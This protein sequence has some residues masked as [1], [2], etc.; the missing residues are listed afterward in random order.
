ME[1][2]TKSSI[3]AQVERLAKDGADVALDSNGS[4]VMIVSRDEHRNLSSRLTP[5][6]AD[7]WIDGFKKG[8][9]AKR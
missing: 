2:H 8:R 6:E 9:D 7:I 5:K 4:G 3:H 1:R